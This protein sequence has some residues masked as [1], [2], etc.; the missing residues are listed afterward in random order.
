[1]IGR[2]ERRKQIHPLRKP[3]AKHHSTAKIYLHGSLAKVLLK[4]LR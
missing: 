2:R 1:M 3:G 4:A